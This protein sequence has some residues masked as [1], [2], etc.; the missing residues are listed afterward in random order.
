M[1]VGKF[2]E[3]QERKFKHACLEVNSPLIDRLTKIKLKTLCNVNIKKHKRKALNL[4]L[5]AYHN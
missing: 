3:E 2:R 5:K 1:K 4:V